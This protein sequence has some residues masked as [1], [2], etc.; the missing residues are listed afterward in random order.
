MPDYTLGKGKVY[1][2]ADVGGTG[3]DV[4]LGN[5][6]EFNFSPSLDKIEHFSSK[7][8]AALKD[9]ELITTKKV[10]VKFKLDE[11]NVSNMARFVMG[12]IAGDVIN[13]FTLTEQKGHLHFVGDPPKGVTWDF[14]AY[15]NLIPD[16]DLA[17]IGSDWMEFGFTFEVLDS[18][19]YA[20]M[21]SMEDISA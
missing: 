1:W 9:D 2:K 16:G 15:G 18:D 8:G 10:T 12:G 19:V 7:S 21:F 20:G 6:P 3:I 5:C 17:L 13:A 11:P 14:K 4:H